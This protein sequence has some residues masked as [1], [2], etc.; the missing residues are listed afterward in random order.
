MHCIE[1]TESHCLN[2]GGDWQG[3]GSSCGDLPCGGQK[4]GACCIDAVCHQL[5][6]Q[7]CAN[8]QGEWIGWSIP[9][10]DGI[11]D[12][13]PVP[14][15][16]CIPTPNGG[17]ICIETDPVHCEWE[18]G[19]WQGEGSACG[20]DPC[21]S[22]EV[23]ACCI[24]AAGGIICVETGEWHC[25]QEGGEW[26]GLNTSCEGEDCGQTQ[27]GACCINGGC[28]MLSP[29][30]CDMVHGVFH[31]VGC[32]EVQCPPYCP[33]DINGDGV[34]NVDDILILLAHWGPCV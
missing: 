34:V 13:P 28:L 1:T 10:E 9:C 7:H 33:G 32:G 8:E 18:G 17:I 21:G 5:T 15:A 22:G 26:R 25:A 6:E 12:E 30:D 3:G 11:C 20:D 29:S 24:P 2:E 4:T 23:G 14:G 16:C 19:D 31:N 27:A